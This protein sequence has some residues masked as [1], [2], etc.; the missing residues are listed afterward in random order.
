MWQ[1]FKT[2]PLSTPLTQI[3]ARLCTDA[4]FA[5]KLSLITCKS[6][7]LN[8]LNIPVQLLISIT[9]QLIMTATQCIQSCRHIQNNL[10]T[11]SAVVERQ[12]NTLIHTHTEIADLL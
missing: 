7:S 4:R 5:E 1:H 11:F 6:M 12:N 2:V 9:D 3:Q 10:N 8:S